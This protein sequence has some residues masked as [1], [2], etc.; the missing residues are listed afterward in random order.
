MEPTMENETN[1][2]FCIKIQKWWRNKLQSII[3][4]FKAIIYILNMNQP[5]MQ[6]CLFQIVKISICYP[7]Q[8]NE[9]K[10]IYGKLIEKSIMYALVKIGFKV[11]D[12]DN[13]HTVGSEYKNDIAL[14]GMKFSIKAK[15]N[16]VGDII[17]IN[18]KSKKYHNISVKTIICCIRA[19]KMYFIPSSIIDSKTFVK[20]DAGCISY[21]SKLLT[22]MNKTHD[23]LIYNFPDLSINQTNQLLEINEIDIMNK[24]FNETIL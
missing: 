17:L 20:E 14:L 22:M 23:E 15:L 7:P 3:N 1:I 13:N 5:I 18:K 19:K 16:I 8:K 24:L 10:F 11:E 6:E 4:K 2:H 12:L 21:K 9:N